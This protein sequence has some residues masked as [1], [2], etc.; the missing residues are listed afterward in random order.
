M[1]KRRVITLGAI[2]GAIALAIALFGRAPRDASA[3]RVPTDPNEVLEVL[4]GGGTSSRE[5]SETAQLRRV[6]AADPKNLPAAVRLARIDIQLSRQHADPRYLGQAQAVLAPWWTDDA[7]PAVLVLRA[8]IEQSLHDFD[9]ALQHLDLA[10][11]AEPENAQAWLT[12]A[13]VLTVTARYDEARASCAKVLPL[14]DP[15]T[16]TICDTQVDALLGKARPAYERLAATLSGSRAA[17]RDMREWAVGV[18]GE[19]AD[20]FGDTAKAEEHF[21][22]ALAI[23]PDDA[24]VRGALADLYTDAKRYDDAIALVKDQEANDALLLRLAIAERRAN[25]REAAGHIA[26]LAARFEASHAR[27]DVVHR[28]EEARFELELRDDPKRAYELAKANW[29]VQKEPWDARIFLAAA[30][31]AH[32]SEEPVRAHVQKTGLEGPGIGR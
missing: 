6:L 14:L 23:A 26:M 32:A 30:K 31:A 27:G 17:S 29:D 2:G 9:S 13:V 1:E 10:L 8:T 5:R 22:E 15:L 7:P 19:Y 3:A 18:L 24:Y 21:K 20:R 25:R 16:F 11:R 28:R 12:R 4:P